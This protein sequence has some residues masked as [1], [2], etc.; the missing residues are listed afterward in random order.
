M[1]SITKA[2]GHAQVR[3]EICLVHDQDGGLRPVSY[4]TSERPN[5]RIGVCA[6]C[7]LFIS[8]GRITLTTETLTVIRHIR[9]RHHWMVHIRH[10]AG[11]SPCSDPGCVNE[12]HYHAGGG[13][14]RLNGRPWKVCT[15]EGCDHVYAIESE[16]RL[17]LPGDVCWDCH[18]R[19][20]A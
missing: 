15:T 20:R 1:N 7:E 19:R 11:V 2:P 12:W 10:G 6:V 3:C 4:S 13:N 8:K 16:H 5:G 18:Q 14:P 17:K 9:A